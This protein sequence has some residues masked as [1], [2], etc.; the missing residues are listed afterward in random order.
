MTF[1]DGTVVNLALPVLQRELGASVAQVQWIV[2]A[3]L[4]F[5]ASLLLTGGALGDRYGR[6]SVF[7]AGITAFAAASVWCGLA[8]NSSQL[9][10]ARVLQGAGAALLVPGSL[11]I[12]SSSFP[13]EERGRAIGIWSGFSSV[14][15]GVGPVLGGWLIENLSWRWIFFSTFPLPLRCF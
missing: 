15:A 8:T 13:A 5:L 11:A 3:Y 1:I 10:A 4:L 14:A 12:I 7:A 2:E 9:I 6:R